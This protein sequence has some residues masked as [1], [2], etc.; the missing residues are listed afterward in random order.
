MAMT[1]SA[2]S[3]KQALEC[4]RLESDCRQLSGSVGNPALQSHFARMA[5]VWSD[6]AIEGLDESAATDT[7]ARK[8]RAA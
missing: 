2:L 1:N 7:A 4:L 6:L 8:I 3:R 5:L